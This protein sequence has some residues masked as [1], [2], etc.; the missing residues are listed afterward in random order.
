MN[1]EAQNAFME[2]MTQMREES[3]YSLARNYLG[4][5]S[6]PFDRTKIARMLVNFVEKEATQ[7]RLLELLDEED[8]QVLSAVL[9]VNEG[10]TQEE[11]SA[12]APVPERPIK[13][14]IASLN[15]PFSVLKTEAKLRNLQERLWLIKTG[16]QEYAINPL[17]R[18]ALGST[19]AGMAYLLGACEET[20]SAPEWWMND[21]F[22]MA[23]VSL[24]TLTP[25]KAVGRIEELTGVQGR[26]HAEA[27]VAGCKKL[28]LVSPSGPAQLQLKAL[29]VFAGLTAHERT[30]YLLAAMALGS[31]PSVK[32]GALAQALTHLLRVYAGCTVRK[33]VVERLYGLYADELMPE[34]VLTFLEDQKVWQPCAAGVVVT[35]LHTP[36]DGAA[37]LT[38][39]PNFQVQILPEAPFILGVALGMTLERFD[40][41]SLYN[42]TKESFHAAVKAGYTA[43]RLETELKQHQGFKLV[44]NFAQTLDNWNDYFTTSHL[45]HGYIFTIETQKNHLL[46]ST[47]A[48]AAFID[49]EIAPCV[50]LLKHKPDELFFNALAKLG[51]AH[52]MN[53]HT[54]PPQPPITPMPV[55]ATPVA[56]PTSPAPMLSG[57][58]DL[59][60]LAGST[61]N[62]DLKY[63]IQRKVI[64]FKEQLEQEEP[65]VLEARGI[66]FQ[67]K[68]RLIE[69]AIE[70]KNLLELFLKRKD[71]TIKLRLLP[72]SINKKLDDRPI[73]A[74]NPSADKIITFSANHIVHIK[75]LE[76]SLI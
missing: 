22:L 50:Y 5:L 60:E 55:F 51:L 30:A 54:Q 47:G 11:N 44:E 70:Q 57:E 73:K 19:S 64:L 72:L 21:P 33:V 2:A 23:L 65:R 38:L 43:A 36:S 59:K 66:D 63:R 14:S 41:L 45:Y 25:A 20:E 32:M 4:Q 42:L 46:A 68:L 61:E 28:H 12:L 53:H 76:A 13:T 8:L 31:Y 3:F 37:V 71:D 27:L 75:M 69:R 26:R 24:L 56:C 7:A 48:L 17:L 62:A 35:R 40:T 49:R 29:E 67:T 1:N 39:E 52:P 34:G 16:G 18:G 74:Y 9:V 6:S 58:N 15:A 10:L